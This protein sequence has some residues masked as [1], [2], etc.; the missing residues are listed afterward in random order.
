MVNEK[1][2]KLYYPEFNYFSVHTLIMANKKQEQVINSFLLFY[3]SY[4]YFTLTTL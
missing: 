2:Y 3:I 1:F 4:I